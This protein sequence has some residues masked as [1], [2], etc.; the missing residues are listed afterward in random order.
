MFTHA[1][2]FPLSFNAI[3]DVSEFYEGEF[4]YITQLGFEREERCLVDLVLIRTHIFH[5]NWRLF[6]NQRIVR[7]STF[8]SCIQNNSAFCWMVNLGIANIGQLPSKLLRGFLSLLGA[9]FTVFV[10]R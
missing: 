3:S 1:P 2:Y 7:K 6:C 4:F 8:K 5:M 10:F 9:M